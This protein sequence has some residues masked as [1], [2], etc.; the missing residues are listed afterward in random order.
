[1]QNVLV[2][3]KVRRGVT[4]QLMGKAA[5]MAKRSQF[6]QPTAL[7]VVYS[8]CLPSILN[9]MC[10]CMVTVPQ[11]P[12]YITC[13]FKN[14]DTQVFIRLIRTQKK[15]LWVTFNQKQVSSSFKVAK[16]DHGRTNTR[17]ESTL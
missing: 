17:D 3:M 14:Q 1:M 2:L 12:S 11:L 16:F 4:V 9:L 13:T 5:G 6:L 7:D 10:L 15:D 8:T